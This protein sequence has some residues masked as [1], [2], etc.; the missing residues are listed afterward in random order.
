MEAFQAADPG[1]FERAA[2]AVLSAYYLHPGVR[3]RMGYPGQG[4]Q[5]I[6]EGEPEHYLRDDILAPVRARGPVYVPTPDGR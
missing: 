2:F 4:A 6:L 1:T 5:P 3:R